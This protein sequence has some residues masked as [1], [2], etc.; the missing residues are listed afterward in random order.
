M[1]GCKLHG[2]QEAHAGQR[3]FSQIP[4]SP[5]RPRFPGPPASTRRGGGFAFFFFFPLADNCLEGVEKRAFPPLAP[6]L[7]AGV[8]VHAGRGCV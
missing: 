6:S 8:F 5:A 3:S 1:I 2:E 4:S 7:S